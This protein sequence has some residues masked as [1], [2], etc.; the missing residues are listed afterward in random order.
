MLNK[1]IIHYSEIA[2]KGGNRPFFEQKLVKSLKLSLDQYITKVYKRYGRIVADLKPKQD[3]KK[4]SAILSTL[5]GIA[6]FSFGAS[7]KLDIEDI[8]KLALKLA[9]KEEFDSFKISA[10]RS[11]KDFK[12]NSDQ[13]NI[14]AG[15]LIANTL[16][17]K[18][19]M[20]NPDV[21]VHID[22][23][24]KEAFVYCQKN[25]GVGGLPIGS[26]GKLVCS[27]SG[28][29]DSP[30]SA[31]MM[32]KR[33]CKI[34]FVHFFNKTQSSSPVKSKIEN[35]VKQLTKIQLSS[36]LYIVPFDE[37]QKEIIK[38]VPS[39]SRMIIYRR[40]MMKILNIIAENEHAKAVVT[41]DS[42][43]QVASQTVENL[44]CIHAAST[45]P[46]FSPLIGLNKEEI[47]TI[48]KQIGTYE[49]SIEPYPDCCSFMIAKHPETK[50]K[51]ELIE[52]IEISPELC[53]KVF[54]ASSVLRYSF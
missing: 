39:E 40:F 36:K 38:N 49:L 32:M 44:Q 9:E 31:F 19:K 20:K 24:E 16:N 29:I 52:K 23:C 7:S 51:K 12:I 4:I 53:E 37:I 21:E 1:I 11:N 47:T 13:I 27:L 41:G 10:R 26:G 8:K 42:L 22:V 48:S 46:V 14:D 28:G 5:P 3:F 6:Y 25:K 43:G 17:K 15:A 50:G 34:V 2:T 33:G 54:K 35:L 18:V 45:I 30:V